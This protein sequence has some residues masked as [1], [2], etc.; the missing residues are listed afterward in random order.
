MVDSLISILRYFHYI[1]QTMGNVALPAVALK[2][3]DC[4]ECNTSSLNRDASVC[5]WEDPAA[6]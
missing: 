6:N 2:N 5:S 4:E 1:I 3:L